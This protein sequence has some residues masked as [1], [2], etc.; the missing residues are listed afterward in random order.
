MIYALYVGINEYMNSS[1]NLSCCKNDVKKV[2][3][4]IS[5]NLPADIGY[6]PCSLFDEDAT[7]DK[8]ISAFYSHL[9]DKATEQDIVLFYFSGHGGRE[10]APDY[11][12]IE[13]RDGFL[14]GIVCHDSVNGGNRISVS[15]E[16]I[17]KR[18][19]TT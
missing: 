8:I 1:K 14:E 7:R 16:S 10:K 15:T 5:G 13:E 2:D 12:L 9:I 11:F 19:N 3:E 17:T 4:Y 6:D 18:Q